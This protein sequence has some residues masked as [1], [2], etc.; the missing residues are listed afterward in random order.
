M[1]PS[2]R[3]PLPTPTAV[4]GPPS[5][6]VALPAPPPFR[7]PVWATWTS[8]IPPSLFPQP[9]P[10]HLQDTVLFVRTITNLI[11]CVMA[12][13][14]PKCKYMLQFRIN[15][16]I[17]QD[18]TALA[19]PEGGSRSLDPPPPFFKRNIVEYCQ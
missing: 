1:F 17:T 5:L 8:I 3:M 10:F 18:S 6:C 11:G 14:S 15:Q 2:Q 16:V 12:A 4:W 7:P 19:D 13:E 9:F